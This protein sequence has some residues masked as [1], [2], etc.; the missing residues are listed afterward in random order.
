MDVNSCLAFATS[1]GFRSLAL[2]ANT[3][4]AVTS[5]IL[6][7]FVLRR[8]IDRPKAYLFA[9]FVAVF[10]LWLLAN[11]VLWNSND[12]YLIAGLWTPMAYFELLFFLILFYFFCVDIF[13]SVPRWL[14]LI[15]LLIASVSFTTNIIG[16]GA[17]GFDQAWCNMNNNEFLASYNL[18]VEIVILLSIL[19]LW[20]YRFARLRSNRI[21]RTRL[22]II[23]A[24]IVFFMGIFSGA[25]YISSN[26]T[27]YFVELYALF[28]LPI[29][30]LLLTVAIT[31]YGTF[32]LGDT[33]AKAL[34]YIFLV[35]SGAEFFFVTSTASLILT[36]VAFLMTLSFGLL[37][38]QSYEREARI[39]A[40]VE[41]LAGELQKT[42]ERQEN[43]IHF[44]GHEV[45]GFL[46]K[47]QGA[48]AA[49]IEGDF[50]E[51]PAE[52]HPFVE[53][54]LEETRG[55]VESVS[56]ILKAA[57][58]KKGT[59]AYEKKPFDLKALVEKAVDSAKPTAEHKGL[60]LTFVIDAGQYQMT[61]DAPQINDHVLRNLID[62]SI[63][64]T[65]TGSV[66]VSLKKVGDKFVFAVKDTGVGITAEDK[67]RL[68]TEG[69][70]GKDSI[71]V[72]VHSTGY[73]LYIAKQII[74]AHGGTVRAESEGAGKGSTFTAEFPAV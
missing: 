66:T 10:S 47:A 43:L 61:G 52:L 27:M 34:F 9:G 30:I 11:S 50:G 31:S 33:V 59:V 65:P 32:R 8:A 53:R 51:M 29:F 46:T 22:S 40:E 24:S 42:N 4:P 69:G 64:Y 1:T 5:I 18:W 62:N 45:K 26:S 14:N 74:E 63:N 37:L 44:I 7:G 56:T 72:N 25:E 12:Y 20:V 60:V 49:L 38:L 73:G 39:R 71:K 48:F 19:G 57:N 70:H 2:Y 36:V 6:A 13:D 55:G 16:Q 23:A 68:F 15:V 54:A 35:F 28:A 21:E 58:L 67:V 41:M 3:V 17:F